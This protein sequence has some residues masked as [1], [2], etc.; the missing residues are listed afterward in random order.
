M[1]AL[2]FGGAVSLLAGSAGSAPARAAAPHAVPRAT[3]ATTVGASAD[4][5]IFSGSPA[6][7]AQC[8]S[9][10]SNDN[11]AGTDG[12][13]NLYRAMISFTS[14]LAI[15]AGSTVESA[16]LTIHVLGAFGSTAA[17][18]VDMTR[19]FAPGVATWNTYD[20]VHPWL[21]AG[22]DFS[23]SPH[24][25][26]TVSS[27]GTVS[28]SVPG[29]V[30]PW[31]DGANPVRQLMIV[32]FTG[33]GNVFSF[34]NRASV[35]GPVLSVTYEPPPPSTT[36]PTTTSPGPVVTTPI[37][38]PLPVPKARHSLHIKIVMSW[39]WR[40]ALVRLRKVT[41]GTMP[42]DTKLALR[43]RGRG[44][45]RRSDTSASGARKVRRMLKGLA[46]RRYHAGDVLM[47]RLTAAGYRPESARIRFRNGKKPL[48]S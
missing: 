5:T 47:V 44:C 16:T 25:V 30:Q 14:G 9:D 6:S 36:T 28:F 2:M 29:L 21:T 1:L 10:P 7:A 43:C 31:V 26:Q 24:T 45:P 13:G 27:A 35:N 32:G 4:C 8:G 19:A 20:G 22:G 38:T 41:T 48:V 37:P 12:S 42:G 23:A 11:L 40:G 39:T 17:T 18:V 46:G 33:T 34:A 3:V 15:P